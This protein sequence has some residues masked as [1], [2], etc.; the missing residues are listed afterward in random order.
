MEHPWSTV[1]LT[2]G[3]VV[4]LV[5]KVS[6]QVHARLALGSTLVG[7]RPVEI[8]FG[9]DFRLQEGAMVSLFKVTV[10][11]HGDVISLHQGPDSTVCL[12]AKPSLASCLQCREACTGL[13]ALGLGIQAAG[14]RLIAQNEMQP[15]T[16]AVAHAISGVP[17][18]VGQ[19]LLALQPESPASPSAA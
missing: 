11:C 5:C 18:S 9:E 15:K 2:A 13:G 19:A 1:S 6:Q 14:F 16:A 4:S 10:S 3:T 17:T 8:I 12:H 7:Q